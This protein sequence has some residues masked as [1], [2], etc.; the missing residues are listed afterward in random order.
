MNAPH[1]NQNE[2]QQVDPAED[3]TEPGAQP[4]PTTRSQW[5]LDVAE[6]LFG[7]QLAPKKPHGTMVLHPMLE[8]KLSQ[9]H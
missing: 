6:T 1:S 3:A 4:G 8:H 7:M 5:S 2:T 9:N